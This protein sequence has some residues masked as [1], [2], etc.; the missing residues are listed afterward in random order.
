M[1]LVDPAPTRFAV[2]A[3]TAAPRVFRG[4]LTT[5]TSRLFSGGIRYATGI[6]IAR[7]FGAGTYAEF[8]IGS[9]LL[10]ALSTLS[11]AGA[12]SGLMGQVA[13]KLAQ[14]DRGGAGGAIRAC[15]NRAWLLSIPVGAVLLAVG[16]FRPSI[17]GVVG[18]PRAFVGIALSFPLLAVANVLESGT[19]GLR[20]TRYEILLRCFLQP[21][22]FLGLLLLGP[23]RIDAIWLVYA[24]SVF[25]EVVAAEI[26]VARLFP[27]RVDRPEKPTRLFQY[28]VSEIAAV[29]AGGA[30]LWIV[31]LVAAGSSGHYAAA[32]RTVEVL[33]VLVASFQMLLAP[34]FAALLASDRGEDVEDLLA[35]TGRSMFLLV[36]CLAI[37]IAVGAE[38]LLLFFRG[39]FAEA[40]TA[41]ALM[42]VA[43]TLTALWAP[44]GSLLLI[45]SPAL[46]ARARFAGAF[47]TA[48]GVL[49]AVPR[50]GL[51]GAGAAAALGTLVTS[52]LIAVSV[53][54]TRSVFRLRTLAGAALLLAA[55]LAAA[56][57][58]GRLLTG[59]RLLYVFLEGVACTAT[60]GLVA[61]L[62]PDWRSEIGRTLSFLSTIRRRRD[63]AAALP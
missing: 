46:L 49:F 15:R 13:T 18:H 17:L 34:S 35:R 3:P 47:V 29:L 4:A 48:A 28:F 44:A 27:E 21:L 36:A 58:V 22:L 33:L 43:P 25:V 54:E 55:G 23:G 24:A 37:P 6:A 10:L 52:I 1:T 31:G 32:S 53:P 30:D 14:G 20:T 51:T 45:R 63:P 41:L 57:G 2:D 61:S 12:V 8:T 59:H 50:W 16:Q 42:V 7:L 39:Q 40:R 26:L 9:V 62:L 5:F 60:I 38:D 11:T 56:A 19:R